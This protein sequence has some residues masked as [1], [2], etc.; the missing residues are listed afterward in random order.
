MKYQRVKV[1][2]DEITDSFLYSIDNLMNKTS[3][4][5]TCFENKTQIKFEK[6]TQ[7]F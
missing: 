4:I 6:F 5:E 1:K 7:Q 3:E 2:D